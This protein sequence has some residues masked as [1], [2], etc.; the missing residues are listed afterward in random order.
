[1]QM[2]HFEFV[3]LC[4]L[5]LGLLDEEIVNQD[6]VHA[7][8]VLLLLLDLGVLGFES[9]KL[10]LQFVHFTLEVVHLILQL[11]ILQTQFLYLQIF[12]GL[13]LDD[14]RECFDLHLVFL[15]DGILNVVLLQT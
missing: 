15:F 12:L 1:M 6:V 8:Q 2:V 5:E 13:Y 3:V 4:V 14:L 10:E 11:L 9:V 7:L